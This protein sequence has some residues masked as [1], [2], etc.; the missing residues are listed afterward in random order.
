MPVIGTRSLR[1]DRIE[2]G[3]IQLRMLAKLPNGFKSPPIRGTRTRSFAWGK[4]TK[5]GLSKAL[6][7][8]RHTYYRL[9]ADHCRDDARF[10]R[11]IQVGAFEGDVDSQVSLAMCFKTESMVPQNLWVKSSS[12]WA[13]L[14][15]S[16]LPSSSQRASAACSGVRLRTLANRDHPE[17]LYWLGILYK[18]GRGVQADDKTAAGRLLKALDKDILRRLRS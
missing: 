7:G 1:W 14:R 9:C 3:R 15:R 4:L 11:A 6:R 13:K 12:G 16:D 8:T 17:G 10:L 2:S 18:D 5:W